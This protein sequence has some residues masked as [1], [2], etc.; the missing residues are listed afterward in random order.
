M[1]LFQRVRVRIAGKREKEGEGVGREGVEEPKRRW[2]GGVELPVSIVELPVDALVADPLVGDVLG[3]LDGFAAG[4]D[5][6]G[7]EG[8]GH[9]PVLAEVVE[10]GGTALARMNL[11]GFDLTGRGVWGNS[12]K[13]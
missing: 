12:I 11:E 9:V 3:P 1:D 7:I 5:G 6:E 4:V 13:R 2:A 10:H 8:A